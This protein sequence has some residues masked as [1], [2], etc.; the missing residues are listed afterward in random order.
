MGRLS[1]RALIVRLPSLPPPRTQAHPTTLPSPLSPCRD[2]SRAWRVA[3]AL[4]VGMVGVNTG[5]I[6][7]TAAPFG[8][9]KQSG[10][11]REGSKHGLD[12]WTNIKYVMMGV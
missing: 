6:S 5:I 3:D 4:Q 2:L 1:L 11:G 12:D 7:H 9:I 8:G 10:F